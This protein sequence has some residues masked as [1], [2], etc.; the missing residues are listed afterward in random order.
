ME[1]QPRNRD[2][3]VMGPQGGDGA[4]PQELELHMKV[5][6]IRQRGVSRGDRGTAGP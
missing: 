6:P 2:G 3:S 5:S 1:L 4:S